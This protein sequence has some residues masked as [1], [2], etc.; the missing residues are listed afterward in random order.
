LDISWNKVTAIDIDCPNLEILDISGNSLAEASIMQTL[1]R[2]PLLTNFWAKHHANVTTQILMYL[3]PFAFFLFFALLFSLFI[4]AA[5]ILFQF[6]IF[7]YFFFLL[8]L[9]FLFHVFYVLFYFIILLFFFA[10]NRAHL[11]RAYA[12]SYA[13]KCSNMFVSPPKI[14]FLG[15]TE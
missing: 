3:P 10:A 9:S 11:P 6:S 12:F 13:R 7:F 15:C 8:L 14:V 5:S 4:L 1:Q 2:A